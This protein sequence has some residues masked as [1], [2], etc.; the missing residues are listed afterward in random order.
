M[1]D[2][3]Q[4]VKPIEV[5]AAVI[6]ALFVVTV[7]F[8]FLSAIAGAVWWVIKLVILVAVLWLLIRWAARHSRN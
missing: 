8:V 4:G 2:E 6:V 5:A 3:H 7:L 1:N